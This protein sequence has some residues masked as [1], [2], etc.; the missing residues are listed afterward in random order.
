MSTPQLDK[1]YD[2]KAVEARWSQFWNQ[3]GYFHAS[4]THP[5]QPYCIVIPPP[6]VTGS[7]HVG[8][9]LN[10]SIQ[11]IL[12]RWRRMQGRNVLWMP[13]TDHA[14]IATQN[15]VEK[16]LM[17]EGAS[18]E[19]LGRER[20]IERVWQWKT[21]FGN[22][23]VSQQKQLGESCDWDRL[24]FTMDEGLSKAVLE[25]F[26]RLYEDGLIYRGERLINWC[27]RCLTA[28]SDIEVEHEDIKGKLYSIEY[29]LEQ[30]PTIRLTVA[31]T[32]PET[33]FG[34]S[35]VAVHPEDPRYNRLI[36]QQ[37]RLPLT[38]R[39]IPIVGDAI[40]VDRE[41][42]TGAVKITPAHDFND[43]EAGERHNLPRLPILDHQALLDRAGLQAA[44]VE[45]AIIDAVAT[46][47]VM[48]ARPKI[49]QVLKDRGWL[50][51]VDDHKM[52]IGKCYRCKTVVEPYLSPQWFVKIKP[53]AEPAIKAVEDGRI[54]II[55]EGWT[56]NYLG[57]MRDI[58]DWCISRQIWWGHQIPAWYCEDCNAGL[59]VKKMRIGD[60]ATAHTVFT[61][62]QGAKPLV[63]RTAPTHCPDCD[64]TKFIR[65]SDVLDTWFSSALW[66]FST[67]GWPDQTPEL[68][69]Y[70]PT[71]TL[72]TGLDILFFWVARMIMM[73]LK[74][75]GDVPFRDVYI[76]ALV[77]DA[78]GQKM[79][80]SKGNV[81][82]P[83][84][85][86]EQFGTDALR[87]TL[88][89]MASPGRDI[90]L[91]E[92]R[93]EGYRNFANKIWNAARFA[94]I[95]LAGIKESMPPTDRSFP[96]LWIRSRLN[97]TI[98]VVTMELEAY[99]FDRATNALYQFFWH[100][101][102]DW[103][104]ELIKPVLQDTMHPQGSATRRML[105]E[106][107]E[108]FLRLLHPFMPFISE[109]I[110]QTLPHTGETIV[111]QPYPVTQPDWHDPS[112][113]ETFHLFEQSIG[114]FRTARVL[115]N[116]SPGKEVRFF[117][118]HE[119]PAAIVRLATLEQDLVHLGRG[120]ISLTHVSQRPMSNVLRLIRDGVTVGVSVEGDVDLNK[121]LDRLVKQIAETDKESQR[122]DGKLKSAD[123]VSK[124]PPEVITD[125][126]DRL[127]VLSRDR[128][129]L[130]SSE[131]QL[132]AMLGA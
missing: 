32:R 28:L 75:M 11:D 120:Q 64:G 17:A 88:A 82:D 56:N 57:W 22:T 76:H 38:N 129:M 85:V 31:T 60:S 81:I 9:A 111:T 63:A 130:T 40:L 2:P 104:L 6:N 94:H 83:L 103:Y 66:P 109:E 67:L 84:H 92:E 16:Q 107:L 65:D 8:H 86:M 102:C 52:A 98:Q 99:R 122:L 33:M 53:L 5:G 27:P 131:Q 55:P 72:V 35:A 100:E 21:T 70:Y 123:F 124:A 121:A 105:Q 34:D 78:E 62:L 61:I 127:R 79:S 54:R 7:L 20:F 96:G 95:Y 26:V 30:D 110:W 80:K 97:D 108:V 90:K 46:L 47:P 49:E 23:I 68:K 42:G 118:T 37:V 13:G 41:F 77:R 25:V 43:F 24:R 48:K 89:S 112:A 116:Y 125:H 71:S 113:E 69:T 114:L 4:P 29:P 117:V 50:T 74:F 119:D 132:R 18:R 93:I 58:K 12:I 51:K 3:Q 39:T 15:V 128:T 44:G 19:S 106:T 1:T 91:A 87:F 36:G 59:F 10:H 115:L 101:Y 14:G 73:G 126:Q 45:P